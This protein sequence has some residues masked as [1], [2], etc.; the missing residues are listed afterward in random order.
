MYYLFLKAH[1]CSYEI[2]EILGLYYPGERVTV[3]ADG[4]EPPDGG[5]VISSAIA[6]AAGGITCA[7]SLG[8]WTDGSF[9][10]RISRSDTFGIGDGVR[11]SITHAV[12]TSL[13]L[14]LRDY[15]EIKMPWGILVGIRPS[16]IVNEMK[17]GG[18]GEE[19]IRGVLEHRYAVRDDKI[20]FLLEVSRNSYKLIN[21]DAGSVSVYVGIPFCPSRCIYCSFDS[22]PIAKYRDYVGGYLDSLESD[23][24]NI[25]R[26]INGRFN[27]DSIYIGGGT[28]T[29]LDDGMFERLMSIV[30]QNFSI[31]DVREFTVEAGR[32][33]TLDGF[34]LECIANSGVSR[35]S[36]NPQTMNDDTLRRIGRAHTVDDIVEKF[37]MA[38]SA[39]F[40][41]I[42]MDMII[43]LPGENIEYVKRTLNELLRLRPENITVHSLAVKRASKL[44]ERMI[45]EGRMPLP[46]MEEAN[47]IMNYAHDTLASASY[48]PYYLYRQKDM[49]GNLENAGYCRSGFECLYNIQQIE[50]KQ[51]IIGFGA[52]S[53]TKTVFPSENRIERY[54]DKKDISEYL[55]TIRDSS[56]RKLEFLR[57]LTQD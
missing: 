1:S 16:K 14:L 11:K 32:P 35:I 2:Y 6:S 30:T 41:N 47:A 17:D 26:F 15:T 8:E 51:T 7:T 37:Q 36:I 45:E 39:G 38:R 19:D 48:A 34:K 12:K 56:A 4:T 20:D 10:S 28:P 25:S 18:A 53:V 27:I 21:R 57:Q 55:R 23:I 42:N 13:F 40:C 3:C 29:A 9:R 43:G 33:D 46:G 50:E 22:Y 54:R 49:V 24:R 5:H 52:D 31:P 44:R